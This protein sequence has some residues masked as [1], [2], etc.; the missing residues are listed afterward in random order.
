[1]NAAERLA[2]ILAAPV[3]IMADALRQLEADGYIAVLPQQTTLE[4]VTP[5]LV[6]TT[7]RA[8]L[9]AEAAVG[10]INRLTGRSFKVTPEVVRQAKALIRVKATTEV[11]L[12]VIR[13]KHVEWSKDPERAIY[14]QPSTLLRLSN[15]QRYRAALEAGPV[16]TAHSKPAF[17]KL[18][19]D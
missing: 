13:A 6:A 14:L 17:R 1:V 16:R 11:V 10:E 15:F 18:G 3:D 2:E 12:A 8:T 5:F 9:L 7:D 4:A 19:E